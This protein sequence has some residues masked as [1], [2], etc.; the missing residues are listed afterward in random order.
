[1][2]ADLVKSFAKKSGKSVEDIEKMWKDVKASLVKQGDDKDEDG[3]YAK[4]VG[5]MKK[6]LKLESVEEDNDFLYKH[7]KDRTL[8]EDDDNEE[9]KSL[10]FFRE[11]IEALVDLD[12]EDDDDEPHPMLE[13]LYDVADQIPEETREYIIEG[14]FDYYDADDID[15]LSDDDDD[16]D[17]DESIFEE[18]ELD[19]LLT[20]VTDR[21]KKRIRY[22]KQARRKKLGKKATTMNFKRTHKF[23]KK[24][25]RFVRR[26]KAMSVSTMRKKARKFNRVKRKGAT[27]AR[28]KRTKKRL[29]YVKNP[30]K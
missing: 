26:K 14:I 15:D 5:I 16:D 17:L 22:L 2:P 25:R 9:Y 8:F 20:E 19:F 30:Y 12:S 11:V 10:D 3:F 7:F 29:K 6:N 28:S 4:L 18:G 23:D 21:K 13:I 27:K 1:M 24:K